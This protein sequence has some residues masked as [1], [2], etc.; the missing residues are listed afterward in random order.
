MANFSTDSD[1]IDRLSNL[2][3]ALLITIISLLPTPIAARTSVLCRRFGHLWEASPSLALISKDF[4]FRSENFVSMVNRALLSRNPSHHL[5]SLRLEVSGCGNQ[6]AIAIISSF[7]AKACS[8]DLRH[9]TMEGFYLSDLLPILPIVFTINSLRC[10]S[11]CLSSCPRDQELNFPSGITLACLRSLSLQLFNIDLAFLNKLLSELCSLED[12]H[13]HIEATPGFSLSSQTI[14][15]LKLIIDNYYPK[16][17]IL[18]LSLPLLE[19]LHL[20]LPYSLGTLSHIHAN[21]PLLRKAVIKL[22]DIREKNVSTIDGLLNCI[23]HVEELSLDLDETTDKE[24]PIPILLESGKD[25][26]KFSNLKHLDMTLCFHEHNLAAVI[27]MLH[28]CPILKS[29][30]LVHEVHNPFFSF[31]NWKDWQSK[32]PRN[33][34][35]NYRYA[36]FKNLHL[37]ENRKEVIKLLSKKCFSKRQARN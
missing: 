20:E 15:R 12:L 30:K 25:V 18:G 11:L 31:F 4:P 3:D 34:D 9:L 27:M 36:Y 13:L 1:P 6:N 14:R 37:E 32:L 2:P 19:S 29:L 22:G 8:L 35:G 21:V 23:S 5:L 33:A 28:N 7:L 10:L 24:P 26:P 17:D 16:L